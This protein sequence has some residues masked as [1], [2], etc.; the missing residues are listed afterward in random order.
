MIQ[1][2]LRILL[3]EKLPEGRHHSIKAPHWAAVMHN[4]VPVRIRLA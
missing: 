4:C 3:G 1:D 2:A